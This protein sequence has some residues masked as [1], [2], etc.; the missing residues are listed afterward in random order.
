MFLGCIGKIDKII[1]DINNLI[2]LNQDCVMIRVRIFSFHLKSRGGG[3]GG[4][5]LKHPFQGLFVCY[6]FKT[7]LTFL[8]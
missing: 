8:I 7:I 1:T 2:T 6:F 3:G 4:V 5:Y